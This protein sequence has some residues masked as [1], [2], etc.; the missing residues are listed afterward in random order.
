LAR[1]RLHL[2][3]QSSVL[4]GDDGLV[5][6]SGDEFNLLVIKRLHGLALQHDHADRGGI[7][8]GSTCTCGAVPE[9]CLPLLPG[10]ASSTNGGLPPLACRTRASVVLVVSADQLSAPH[11][12][13]CPRS[14][15]WILAKTKSLLTEPGPVG[16]RVRTRNL[17][18]IR[19]HH[20]SAA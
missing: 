8:F 15:R 9:P 19:T 2:I 4:D 5:R 10:E 20:R 18:G 12:A 6:K 16:T 13:E 11:H 17:R 1:S 7:T 14:D 3:K